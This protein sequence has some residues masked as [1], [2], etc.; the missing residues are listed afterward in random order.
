MYLEWR[1]G[2]NGM[3][4]SEW[5]WTSPSFLL[6]HPSSCPVV[7]SVL[8]NWT[9]VPPWWLNPLCKHLLSILI[10][11]PH[12][13]SFFWQ[14]V[15]EQSSFFPFC[16]TTKNR[17]FGVGVC[18]KAQ[19]SLSARVRFAI[20][21]LTGWICDLRSKGLFY[22]H[23]LPNVVFVI[24]TISKNENVQLI[25][26]LNKYKPTQ[27]PFQKENWFPSI[28]QFQCNG[29]IQIH[30]QLGTQSNGNGK[31]KRAALAPLTCSA[32]DFA[33]VLICFFLS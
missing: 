5:L 3:W 24:K 23:G 27:F 4:V 10:W 2:I 1:R 12:F 18:G 13:S 17:R 26:R 16:F 30:C 29:S 9:T 28:E 8:W 25:Y 21:K 11:I 14:R 20:C 32:F 22:Y 7:V 31:G 19:I 6:S 33:F 15:K